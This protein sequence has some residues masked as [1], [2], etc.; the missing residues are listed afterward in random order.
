M[1]IFSQRLRELRLENEMTQQHVAGLL[2]IKQ[3]SY[4]RYE[5]GTGEPS[6]NTLVKLTK[7]FGVTSDYLLGISDEY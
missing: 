2:N 6:I 3:Q 5:Y 1:S 4:I 7:I